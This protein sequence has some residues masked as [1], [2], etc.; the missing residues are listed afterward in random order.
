M[1]DMNHTQPNLETPAELRAAEAAVEALARAEHEAAPATLEA[2]LFMATRGLLPGVAPVVVV[3]RRS[4]F[5]GM[6]MAAAI[7]LVGA[8]GATWLARG[9]HGTDKFDPANLE[10][11]VDFI[12]AMKSDGQAMREGIDSLYLDAHTL[13]DSLKDHEGAPLDEGAM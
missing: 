5:T 9:G 11:D 1:S 12:L 3:R 2:R 13:G 7:A 8:I 6:R 10:A 4:I